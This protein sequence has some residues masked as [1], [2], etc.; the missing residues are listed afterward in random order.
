MRSAWLWANSRAVNSA[1]WAPENGR[2]A[3]GQRLPSLVN[4]EIFCVRGEKVEGAQEDGVF[5]LSGGSGQ[6]QI[7]R[8]ARIAIQP[9][10]LAVACTRRVGEVDDGVD[11]FDQRIGFWAVA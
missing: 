9:S 1:R 6:E 7:V 4:G 2:R 3:G 8:A 11:V 10:D 5:D